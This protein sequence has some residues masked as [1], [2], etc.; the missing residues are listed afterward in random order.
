ML[1]NWCFQTVVLKWCFNCGTLRVPRILRKSNQSILK[2]INP[3][4]HW[5]NRYWSWSSNTLATWCEELTHWTGPWCWERLRAGEESDRGWDVG[6]HHQLNGLEFEQTPAD[7][8]QGGLACCSPWAHKEL[9]MTEWLNNNI[10]HSPM[11]FTHTHT[12]IYIIKIK[13][14]NISPLLAMIYPIFLDNSVQKYRGICY[15]QG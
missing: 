5:K 2:E 3:D 12:Q 7:N 13:Q 8:G 6:W 4:I 15:T 11:I 14:K 10:K 1:K 9:Q